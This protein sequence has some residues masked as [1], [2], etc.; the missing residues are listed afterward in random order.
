MKQDLFKAYFFD[1]GGTLLRMRAPIGH[2]IC[3]V[4]REH[5]AGA[6]EEAVQQAFEWKWLERGGFTHLRT[7]HDEAADRRWWKELVT[8][9]LAATG[10]AVPDPES[11]FE[12]LYGLFGSHEA[13]TLFEDS[14]D[15]LA[16]L[17]ARGKRIAI[18]SNW[19]GQLERICE[20]LGIRR[21][22]D[23]IVTSASAQAAKPDPRIF[24]LGL[25]AVGV[26]PGEVV[27]VGDNPEEDVAGATSAG[28]AA[29]LLQRPERA[30][31]AAGSGAGTPSIRS[32]RELL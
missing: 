3:G 28:L 15:T 7:C 31:H 8:E 10:L 24:L 12:R 5:G 21:Y 6:S 4:A 19:N 26:L 17:R 2:L 9:V 20:G 22:V 29:V 30:R 32:L 18:V 11:F 23:A 25:R 16:G 14:A 13:W 1:A 27:H